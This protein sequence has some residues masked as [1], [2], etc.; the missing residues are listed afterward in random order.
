MPRVDKLY[1]MHLRW[2]ILSSMDSVDQVNQSSIVI[3][4]IKQKVFE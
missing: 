2:L 4:N 3:L 1:V